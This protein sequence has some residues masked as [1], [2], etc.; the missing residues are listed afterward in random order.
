[1]MHHADQHDHAH[2]E[3]DDGDKHGNK[4]EMC[5]HD[6]HKGSKCACGCG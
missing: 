6:E 2:D 3:H 5:G 4:C 1:M